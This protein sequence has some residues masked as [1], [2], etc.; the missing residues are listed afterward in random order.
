M[1]FDSIYHTIL[2]SNIII[3][4]G[5]SDMAVV[6]FVSTK[7]LSPSKKFKKPT[8]FRHGFCVLAGACD[9]LLVRHG[10]LPAVCAR[11]NPLEGRALH[12]LLGLLGLG[13]L[14]G[15]R[16]LFGLRLLGLGLG[17][18]LDAPEIK[19]VGNC[20]EIKFWAPH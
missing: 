2:Y 12:P 9:Y 8:N 19:P 15:L 1:I 18:L 6:V 13:R 14:L 20:V 11:K 5:G 3:V 17:R 16:L 10:A 7:R 4:V